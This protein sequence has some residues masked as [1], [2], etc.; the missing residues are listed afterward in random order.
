MRFGYLLHPLVFFPVVAGLS[1]LTR[2]ALLDAPLVDDEF[3]HVIVGD[4]WWKTGELAMLDGIYERGAIF[5]KLVAS[6]FAIFGENSWTAAR[7]IPATLPNILTV[8]VLTAWVY[9]EVG[10]STAVIF[11]GLFVFWPDGIEVAQFSR[12]YALH[13]LIFSVGI[14]FT[15]YACVKTSATVI[16]RLLLA[17]GALFT[18]YFAI[19]LQML[20]IATIAGVAVWVF[21]SVILPVLRQSL[22]ITLS[23]GLGVVLITALIFLAGFHLKILEIW[24]I[25]RT[26]P[27]GWNYDPTFYHRDLR[28]AYPTLWP[29]L[30]LTF[31]VAYH[32][33]PRLTLL[34]IAIFMSAFVML[35]LGHRVQMRYLYHAQ[36][37]LFLIWAIGLQATMSFVREFTLHET[38]GVVS[39]LR[40]LPLR[41]AAMVSLIGC[42]TIFAVFSNPA[43]PRSAKLALG[44][45]GGELL[46]DERLHWPAVYDAV[47]PWANDGALIVSTRTMSSIAYLGDFDVAF[48]RLSIH[49][50]GSWVSDGEALAAGTYI[51]DPRDGRALI[52]A[53]SEF[54]RLIGCTPV[55][56]A[57]S[58]KR[59][60]VLD[61][62]F[63]LEAADADLPIEITIEDLGNAK[64]F[65]WRLSEPPPETGCENL[66]IPKD[67]GA[68]LRLVNGVS[69]PL[70]QFGQ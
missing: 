14:V 21:W 6:S 11:S 41:K 8:L 17:V 64:I 40:P 46:G 10:R 65:G 47:M 66:P 38:V 27:P 16:T 55:G 24:S 5:T 62:V 31:I 13:G 19:D 70:Y 68:A 1:F 28:E 33:R 60:R 2:I 37:F 58:T 35:S 57:I 56:V 23:F 50:V 36:P 34:C 42:M 18:F 61:E 4:N 54:L 44:S 22:M 26:L 67:G 15:Y 32:R 39:G 59:N 20:T 12:F 53:R 51:I 45:S 69:Q 25:Y 43:F 9:R 3:F 7:F 48:S 29:L 52:G 49:D 63:L 30:V